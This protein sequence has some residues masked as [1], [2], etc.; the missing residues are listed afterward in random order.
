MRGAAAA[1]SREHVRAECAVAAATV[2]RVDAGV[3]CGDYVAGAGHERGPR[4]KKPPRQL[5]GHELRISREAEPRV[6]AVD[7][8]P[9][10]G[11][12]WVVSAPELPAPVGDDAFSIRAAVEVSEP[13]PV[14]EFV[15]GDVELVLRR[16]RLEQGDVDARGPVVGVKP[17]NVILYFLHIEKRGQRAVV[18]L[19]VTAEQVDC[20]DSRRPGV[21]PR[22]FRQRAVVSAL[23]VKRRHRGVGLWP[24]HTVP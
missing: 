14:K 22:V 20:V 11:K 13:C 15:E 24:G 8:V 3:V 1:G 7:R 5:G 9:V 21:W 10:H 23:C 2:A 19:E 4:E 17:D 12:N 18:K 6:R 16:E